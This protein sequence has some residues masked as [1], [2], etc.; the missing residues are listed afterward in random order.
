MSAQKLYEIE[1]YERY[2]LSV[3]EVKNQIENC[4]VCGAKL[5]LTHITDAQ[6]MLAQETSKCLDCEYGTREV[7]HALN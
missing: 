6:N 5:I 2:L 1:T 3:D 7:Y 4:P